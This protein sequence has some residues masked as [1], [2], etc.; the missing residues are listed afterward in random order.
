MQKTTTTTLGAAF[1]IVAIGSTSANGLFSNTILSG[2]YVIQAHGFEND[3]ASLYGGENDML[4][5]VTF[6]G[7]GN[8]A[9]GGGFSFSHANNYPYG[10]QVYCSFPITG[11]TYTVNRGTGAGTVTINFG[12]GAFP[13]GA[14]ACTELIE[15]AS[16]TF[17]FVVNNWSPSSGAA[18]NVSLQLVEFTQFP[19]K[20]VGP[21]TG[22][23]QSID[24]MAMTGTLRF[25]PS[26]D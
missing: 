15:G 17:A 2:G 9:P 14:A 26:S 23:S 8:V 25:Q 3:D 1:L 5:L 6:D 13:G 16:L 12:V 19:L 22:Y 4:G 7:T 24:N 11:G 18:T 21:P 20:I 10:A